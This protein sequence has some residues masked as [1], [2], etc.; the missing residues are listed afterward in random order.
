[1]YKI[2]IIMGRYLPGYKDGGPVRSIKNLVDSLGKEYEFHILTCDRD[3]GDTVSYSGIVKS[4]YNQ[5]GNALVYYTEPGGFTKELILKLSKDVD[6]IY[7]CGCF[8]DYARTTLGLKKKGNIKIPVAVA[9]M[10]LFSPREFHIKYLKKK[11]FVM[12]YNVTGRFDDIYWSC[13]SEREWKDV[14][15]QIKTHDNYFIAR[16]LPRRVDTADIKKDK[17]AGELKLFFIGRISPVKNL[18]GA[19]KTLEYVHG[20][21]R[22]AIYGA[23]QNKEYWGQCKAV[24]DSLPK[25]VSWKWAGELPSEQVVDTLKKEDVLLLPSMG[26]NY[27]HAIQEALSAGCPCVIS[28]QTSWNNLEDNGCGYECHTDD[29]ASMAKHIDE[30]AEMDSE[31]FMER[32]KKA[33]DFAITVSN[34]RDV[35]DQYRRMFNTLIEGDQNRK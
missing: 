3:H 33:H 32:V 28:D 9:S 21:V 27:G 19:A 12:L 35:G 29:Y 25:N 22:F 8:N 4:E 23:A 16:D 10:G 2:L 7:L 14:Q 26:E 24:L 20:R 6:M 34:G 30:Y 1:M 15:E 13:S 17:A 31:Q 5:V 18:L 11:A